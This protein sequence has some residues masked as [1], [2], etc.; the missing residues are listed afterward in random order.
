M[1]DNN[2]VKTVVEKFIQKN[3]NS[4]FTTKDLVIFFNTEQRERSERVEKKLDR[5]IAWGE[6]ANN[7]CVGMLAEHDKIIQHIVD[8]LPEKGFCDSMKKII[9]V[10]HPVKSEPPLNLKVDALWYDRKILK[11]LIAALL[12]ATLASIGSLIVNIAA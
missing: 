11:W 8:V 4:T 1:V 3:G 10:W 9:N 7:S 6:D 2:R 5:H 12:V